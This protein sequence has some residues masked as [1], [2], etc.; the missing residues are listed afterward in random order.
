[1]G[2][3]V[4]DRFETITIRIDFRKKMKS[5]YLHHGKLNFAL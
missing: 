3:I 4:N 1:M 2:L 5:N